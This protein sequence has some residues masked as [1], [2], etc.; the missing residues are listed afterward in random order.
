MKI[1]YIYIYLNILKF[2]LFM[3]PIKNGKNN[4][5]K[6]P[7]SLNSKQTKKSMITKSLVSNKE[8]NNTLKFHQI[9]NP[10]KK[11]QRN[12]SSIVKK[13]DNVKFDRNF[14]NN[15]KTKDIGKHYKDIKLNNLSHNKIVGNKSTNDSSKQK[16]LS[17]KNT[18]NRNESLKKI[19]ISASKNNK[20]SRIP[21]SL[22]KNKSN[23]IPKTQSNKLH[24]INSRTQINKINSNYKLNKY[25]LF[26]SSGN[27]NNTN[28]INELFSKKKKVIN[29]NI[30]DKL[31]IKNNHQKSKDNSF[32]KNC[33]GMKSRKK[34]ES[35]LKYKYVKDIKDED[36]NENLKNKT[37]IINNSVNYDNYINGNFQKKNK[38]I[39]EN[40]DLNSMINGP[41]LYSL[42][43][44]KNDLMIDNSNL[45]NNSKFYYKSTIDN[46]INQ[47]L[48]DKSKEEKKEE[49]IE[50][51]EEKKKEEI[52]EEKEEKKK[53]E[54][55]ENDEDKEIQKKLGNIIEN[56]KKE[57][58]KGMYNK[59][60]NNNINNLPE[61]FCKN[62]FI[63]KENE[64]EN[65]IKNSK[66]LQLRYED[67]KL[68]IN[69]SNNYNNSNNNNIIINKEEKDNNNENFMENK[70][71]NMKREQDNVENKYGNQKM[72][73]KD[74]NIVTG[75]NYINQH[76]NLII[77]RN[78]FNNGLYNE[79]DRNT[80]SNTNNN[81]ENNKFSEQINLKKIQKDGIRIIDT[82]NLILKNSKI[83]N[84]EIIKINM[85]KIRGKYQTK[86]DINKIN[87]IENVPKLITQS[88]VGLVNLGETCYMN[89]GLQNL[90][91]C[92]P[93]INQFFSVL[94]EFKDI[95]EQKIITYSFLNLCVSLIKN[96]NYNNRFNINSYNPSNFRKIFC[97][98]HKEYATHEQHDSL[99]F[100]RILLDD[101]S[102]E[103]N[104]TKII[105]Q[106]KELTTE[107]KSK[108]EQ[109]Y[110][111]NNFYL[112]RENSIIVK[113]F[114]SQIMNVFTCDC[115]DI[116]Y[117]FEKILD[118]PLLFPKEINNINNKEI[119]LY[120]LL[121]H[122]F[123]GE[124]ISWA[125][126]CPKCGQKDVER[127]KS[128]KLSIL[129]N[130]II[131]S[132][133][134][135]NPITGV[136]INKIIKFDEIIDLKSFC[137]YDFFN[138]EINTKYKL[139]GISN[140][141][142]TINFGH[143]YSYTKIGEN[144][145]E[146]NDSFVKPI[147]LYLMS[148]AAYFFFYEKIE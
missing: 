105:S 114:Y 6:I 136:K 147:N 52:I 133:Q 10:E 22:E 64:K 135:F 19:I 71:S 111:Y 132:L 11:V 44:N 148:R 101:I 98:K 102:K 34:K 131:F 26:N 38:T 112:R 3:N 115:G 58:K 127:N 134:R 141:S 75:E 62:K 125:L 121:Y 17:N 137:D 89:T 91:H 79:N 57:R 21:S 27:N 122:Y 40:K 35:E 39:I 130:I 69:N 48:K 61:I 88:L 123:H 47:R 23:L 12:Q 76:N 56:L 7:S 9:L 36:L 103:L 8:N 15:N 86:K 41:Y 99:E 4:N 65:N 119:D 106:Y 139:Y 94:N 2:K 124:K 54:K 51:K 29:N 82:K 145:Y 59:S 113:V 84:N 109:N 13:A 74:E 77:K 104:Q 1:L 96:D 53:E 144:W 72:K 32:D 33:S 25:Y 87:D 126:K 143:Y 31:L 107:G 78:N 55:K 142:G 110:E 37:K 116:S 24:E 85:N 50:E 43:E 68:N 97:L 92:M 90:I 60:T 93:F 146:F 81:D 63:N 120:D 14:F 80:N 18:I 45:I 108:E 49:I 28:K 16:I 73:E 20:I 67:F 100:L 118:I 83:Q 129:P 70:E 95:L 42:N 117:S 5:K 140:H 138:G 66:N 30:F 128:I 46:F